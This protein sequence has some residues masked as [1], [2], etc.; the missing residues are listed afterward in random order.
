MSIRIWD[1]ARA[2]VGPAVL[3]KVLR[4][5][6]DDEKVKKAICQTLMKDPADAKTYF[7]S[8]LKENGETQLWKMTDL[9]L[10]TLATQKGIATKGKTRQQLLNE[11]Q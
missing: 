6:G 8:I 3:G 11:L 2:W 4:E 7:L 9:N 10:M 5:T 1:I